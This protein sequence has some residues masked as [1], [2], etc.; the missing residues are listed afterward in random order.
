MD[1]ALLEAFLAVAQR[2][3]F[4]KAATDLGTT[5]PTLSHQIRRLEHQMG[6]D[7]FERSSRQVTLTPAGHA[8]VP[9]AR[10]V[11]ADLERATTQCR[12]AAANQVGHLKIGSIG[13][14][15]NNVTP[16]IVRRLRTTPPGLSVHLR[17][18]DSPA[19]LAALRTHEIDVGIVRSASP[20]SDIRLEDLHHEPMT[21]AVPT[22]HPLAAESVVHPHALDGEPLI[23]WPRNASPVFRDQIL[24]YYER[25][26][27]ELTIAMEGAD[28]ET[29]LGLVAAG[30][31]VSL[32]PASFANL[33]RRGVTFRPVVDA[34]EPP[35]NS[36]GSPPRPHHT[37]TPSLR[38]PTPRA[39]GST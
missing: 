15:L 7:L 29:Q 37:S 36:P 39:A 2:L 18:L 24:A 3:H 1:T 35:S 4:A 38:P 11:L 20:A 30:I 16:E 9:E 19:Q 33:N 22:D 28:I 27:I 13:A 23:I 5:Q 10:R 26:G 17:Q 8:L 31:G 34:P 25:A 21:L 14:A 32:Q 12:A 6:T